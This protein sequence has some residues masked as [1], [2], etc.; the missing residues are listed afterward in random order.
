MFKDIGKFVGRYFQV[1][2]CLSIASIIIGAI[3]GNGL[4][5]DL[6]F[7]LFF[8][9]GA[10]LIKHHPA[11]RNWTIGLCGLVLIAALVLLLVALIAGAE[12]MYV[13]FF[14]TRIE[15]PPLWVVA[16]VSSALLAIIGFPFALLLTPQA[17]REFQRLPTNPTI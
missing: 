12:H 1:L 2:G 4:Q 10:Y 6:S 9:A 11:A 7:I 17:R 15:N 13:T 8:W 5:L 3:L 14:G 16:I